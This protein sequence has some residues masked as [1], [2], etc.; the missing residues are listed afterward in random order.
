MPWRMAG[1]QDRLRRA[2]RSKLRPLGCTVTV[3]VMVL[4]GVATLASAGPRIVP[5]ILPSSEPL[6]P[7]PARLR[8]AR[9]ADRRLRRRRPARAA[10]AARPLARAGA[11]LVAGAR[12]ELRAAGAVPLRGRPRRCRH[13]AAAWPAWPTRCCTWRRRPAQGA[14]RPAHAAHLL[15]ALARGGRVRRL[16][17]GSTSGVYGD[18]GGARFDETRAVRARPRDARPA[19]R[20]C[21]GAL[22]WLRPRAAAW[23]VSMLRIP[24]IYAPDRDGGHPRER[25]RARHAGAARRGR[26]LHQPHPCRR[27]GARLRGRAVARRAAARRCTPATTA[28]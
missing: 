22:R 2:R 12:A 17:Y 10:A 20:R 16:V 24:G 13:A 5:A 14:Q 21:R 18:C 7:S 26:R 1:R 4:A 3:K 8:R 11:D 23:R 28:S 6:P 15:Q 9:A 25:L 27:P 19:P